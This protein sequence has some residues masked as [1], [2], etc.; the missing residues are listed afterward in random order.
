MNMDLLD[1][2]I[3]PLVIFFS[4]IVAARSDITINIIKV[5]STRR[6]N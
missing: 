4:V 5:T 6:E 2:V 3:W 1:I